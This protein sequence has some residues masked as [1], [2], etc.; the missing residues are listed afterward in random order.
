MRKRTDI[1]L[2]L[3]CAIAMVA[4][5]G[6]GLGGPGSAERLSNA[7]PSEQQLIDRFLGALERRDP[8]ALRKLRVTEAEYR[9]ILMPGGVPE[10]RPLKRPSKA[11]A[12]L[13]W[14]LVDTKSRYYE[15]SLLA[16]FGGRTLRR[17]AVAYEGGDR[18]FAN[19]TVHEQLRLKLE[20]EVAGREVVLATGSIVEVGGRY[21]FASFIR[22]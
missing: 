3:G 9:E 16:E 22:D 13:A 12:D 7:E 17:K 2:A 20:D 4:C 1:L 14:G 8:D 11:L 6:Q 5:L 21:K 19:H 15:Q 10:G 18:R